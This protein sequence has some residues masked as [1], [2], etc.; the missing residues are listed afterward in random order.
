MIKKKV[1]DAINK[2]INAELYSSYLYLSMAAYFE[3]ENVPGMANWMRVQSKEETTHGMKLYDFVIERGGRVVLDAIDKPPVEWKS[4]LD[5]F[6]QS[7]AH[8][9]KVTA[10]I[11]ALL[12]LAVAEKDHAT[13][14]MLQ[15][16]VDEQVE[17]EANA[18]KIV[19]NLKLA[20]DVAGALFMIDKEL[21]ARTFVDETA[22][23]AAE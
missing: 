16:F 12:D 5:V 3:E 6:E 20:G 23:G 18:E 1:L 2:Q 17:E 15:W 7:L 22:G 13:A 11:G 19:K 4:P 8:E 10:M 21:A 14:S 9:V